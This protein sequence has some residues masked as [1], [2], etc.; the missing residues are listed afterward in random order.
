[1]SQKWRT[2]PED[3]KIIGSITRNG[4]TSNIPPILNGK[5]SIKPL[6]YPQASVGDGVSSACKQNPKKI[7]TGKRSYNTVSKGLHTLYSGIKDKYIEERLNL[8]ELDNDENFN[9]GGKK[10]EDNLPTSS[11]PRRQSYPQSPPG[12]KD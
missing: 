12:I 4:V 3:R 1:M 8:K 7:I 11:R 10:L 6:T 2:I 5:I 9:S